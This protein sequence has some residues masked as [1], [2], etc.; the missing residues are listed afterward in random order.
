M[1]GRDSADRAQHFG[2]EAAATHAEEV[3]RVEAFRGELLG[4]LHR[5]R[6]VRGHRRGH[7]EPAETRLNRPLV[8]A[9]RRGAPRPRV[10]V[11]DARDQAFVQKTIDEAGRGRIRERH[12]GHLITL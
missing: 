4:E 1:A 3:D 8:G 5:T 12:G 10:S 6:D 2:A 7:V 9:S 11:P